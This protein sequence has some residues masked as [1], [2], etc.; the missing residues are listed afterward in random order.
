MIQIFTPFR[1]LLCSTWIV[2]PLMLATRPV[3]A[4]DWPQILGPHRN[5]I[6]VDE[7][8]LTGLQP[9]PKVRWS[10]PVGQ[11]YAGPVVVGD[12]V[13]VFHRD[14][15]SERLD[16]FQRGT[17]EPEYHIEFEAL[18]S[19]VFNS[20]Q[21]PRCVP[22]VHEG[23]IVLFGAA[24]A[25]HVVEIDSGGQRWSRDL[26]QDYEGNEGYFGAGSTPIVIGD[27]ILVN[28]GGRD[29]SG[30]VA[31]DLQ[32]GKTQWKATNEAASYSSPVA[33]SKDG[34]NVVFV[35][36]LN[37][38]VVDSRTG[39]IVARRPFGKRGPTVNAATPI[40]VD[41][42]GL[43]TASYGVGAVFLDLRSPNMDVLWTNDRT[44]SS[45]YNTPIVH[46]GY[47]YGI[48]G[49]EDIGRADLRCVELRTGRVMWSE[50]NFGVAHLIGV[51]DQ[52][53][54]LKVDGTLMLVAADP[55]KFILGGTQRLPVGTTRA[56]P[57]LSNGMLFLRDDTKLMAVSL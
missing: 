1:A 38:L 39:E 7:R 28:V 10:R 36:R 27:R 37:A 35:T 24:G 13:L 55:E 14:G 25:M 57:A 26:Y 12:R 56:L 31:L 43:F 21:G 4:G 16:V 44:M 9:E 17:G 52:M 6:A 2:I 53:V 42:H 5:G 15:Q 8:P 11:G 19:G 54:I 46:Q 41:G 34:A 18:Y 32:T 50:P 49:R 20:D 40:V 48:H 45:Q 51:G 22:V 23:N 3:C 47:M 30:I 33:S 29:E